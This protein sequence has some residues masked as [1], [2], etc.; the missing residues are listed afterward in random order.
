MAENIAPELEG[1]DLA[2]DM[3]CQV[4]Y[5][6]KIFYP[7]VCTFKTTRLCITPLCLCLFQPQTPVPHRKNAF[8]PRIQPSK[9]FI[10]EHNLIE[11]K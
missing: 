9:I 4:K 8:P 6:G 1:F 2:K 3:E 5:V 11:H 7:L 10:I